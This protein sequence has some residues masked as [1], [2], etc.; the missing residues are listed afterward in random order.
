ML[1]AS[2]RNVEEEQ[3]SYE[4]QFLNS[5]LLRPHSSI[6]K[7]KTRPMKTCV[8]DFDKCIFTPESE[9]Y[10]IN[11]IGGGKYGKVYYFK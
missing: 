1:R 8:I 11:S 6:S 2:F 3:V 5:R 4:F 7:Q 10:T 9:C